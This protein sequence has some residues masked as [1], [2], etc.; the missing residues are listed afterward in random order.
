MR[1]KA[2]GFGLLSSRSRGVLC[3]CAACA[4]WS[5]A[6]VTPV[7]LPHYPSTLLT[8]ARY[9]AF[10]LVSL[11]LAWAGPAA[12]SPAFRVREGET[13][14]CRPLPAPVALRANGWP[15]VA[16]QH[17][18]RRFVEEARVELARFVARMTAAQEHGN[19]ASMALEAAKVDLQRIGSVKTAFGAKPA[20][21]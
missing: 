6:F 2:C 20:D 7:L 13:A 16:R 19:Q 9:T 5:V 10:G 21:G 8:F 11:P 4:L 15:A 12:S 18:A 3:G 14:P 1:Q 17:E